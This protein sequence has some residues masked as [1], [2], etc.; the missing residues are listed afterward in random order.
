MLRGP[1]KLCSLTARVAY[2]GHGAQQ[3]H[4]D[5]SE[6]PSVRA[7]PPHY[8]VCNSLWLLD[9]FTPT[10]GA[11]RV[12][13]ASHRRGLTGASLNDASAPHPQQELVQGDQGSGERS[14]LKM[15]SISQN[16]SKPIGD[17]SGLGPYSPPPA[18]MPVVEAV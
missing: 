1:F 6:E 16:E 10:N 8:R 3:F 4:P 11:T 13:P 9:E 14:S 18:A 17:A 7:D 12:L 15:R 2:P 5:W